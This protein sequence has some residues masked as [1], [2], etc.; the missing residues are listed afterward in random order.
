M[1]FYGVDFDDQ[2]SSCGYAAVAAQPCRARPHQP[3]SAD[4]ERL[5]GQG[6]REGRARV[7]RLGRRRLRLQHQRPVASIGGWRCNSFIIEAWRGLSSR[8]LSQFIETI[9]F[10]ANVWRGCK[11]CVA[12]WVCKVISSSHFRRIVNL[13]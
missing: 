4:T 10:R 3:V 5:L 9:E 2:Q 8:E 11:G 13:I 6:A 7:E 1:A 12:E